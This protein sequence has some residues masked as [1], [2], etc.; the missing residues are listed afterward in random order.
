MILR[1]WVFI[2][3]IMVFLGCGYMPSATYAQRILGDQIYV[4]VNINMP[5]PENSVEFKDSLNKAIISRL[6]ARL[7]NQEEADSIITVDINQIRDYS[8]SISSDGF[9]NYY[10][11]TVYVSY[12]FDDKKGNKNTYNA[13]GYFDYNVSLDNPLTTYNNRYYAINQA[14]LQTVDGFIARMAFE[15][16]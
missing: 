3:F 4:K 10:R 16:Q 14:F 9:T 2:G 6:Q 11:V 7:G 12:T 8:I 5:N 13:S 1:F 15:G